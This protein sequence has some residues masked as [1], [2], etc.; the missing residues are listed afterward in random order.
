MRY[1]SN[2]RQSRHLVHSAIVALALV[3]TACGSDDGAA[4][5]TSP[6]GAV[7]GGSGGGSSGGASSGALPDSASGSGDAFIAW[8][9]SWIDT[10]DD[11]AAPVAYGRPTVP[12][13]DAG[14][15]IPL[16]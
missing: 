4:P 14:D 1:T 13:D 9:K 3:V 8:M 2:S 7:G 15:P 6:D 5:A 12:L 10:T 16:R 11:K